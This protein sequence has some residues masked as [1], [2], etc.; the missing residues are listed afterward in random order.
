MH[1][2]RRVTLDFVAQQ[3]HAETL[4]ASLEAPTFALKRFAWE[5]PDRLVVSGVFGD[6]PDPVTLGPPVLVV[7]AGESVHDLPAVAESVEGPPQDGKVWQAQF[8]WQDAPVAF[9]EAELRLG[10]DLTVLLPEPS[11]KRRL[12]RARN[13]LEVRISNGADPSPEA[14]EIAHDPPPEAEVGV[15]AKAEAEAEAEPEHAPENGGPAAVGAQVELLAAQEEVR[16]VRVSLQQTEAELARAREDLEAERTRQAADSERFREGLAQVRETAERALADEHRTV[17]RLDSELRDAKEAAEV[18]DAELDALGEQL[19][20]AD[21]ARTQAEAT[22]QSEIDAL[23]EQ[24]AKLERDGGETER[25]RA[26]LEEADASI[27]QAR[28]DAERLLQR[29]S[30]IRAK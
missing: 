30:A 18:K 10:A 13:M 17:S 16:A 25:L 1:R 23:R 20:A 5:T 26:E 27:E 8:S 3:N 4:T 2:R 11:E 14:T 24:V 19:V 21:E 7:R 22:A 15:V 9:A 29:L 28:D 12:N 6:L